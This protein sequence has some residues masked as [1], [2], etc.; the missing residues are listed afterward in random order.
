MAGDTSR[1][2]DRTVQVISLEEFMTPDGDRHSPISHREWV[3]AFNKQAVHV[4]RLYQ[5]T[6][7]R[8]L[9]HG[10][11]AVLVM[12]GTLTLEVHGREDARRRVEAAQ[13]CVIS[14]G[15]RYRLVP[16]GPG[17][18]FL[19]ILPELDFEQITDSDHVLEWLAARRQQNEPKHERRDP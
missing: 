1:A 8:Q 12:Q 10:D 6:P 16:H 17:V 15:R 4:A 18:T 13:I 2:L 11:G 9:S 3:A 5:E 7:W 19:A 14:Q